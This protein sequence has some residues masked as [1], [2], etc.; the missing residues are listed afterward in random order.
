MQK[1]RFDGEWEILK[2]YKTLD[3]IAESLYIDGELNQKVAT[4][5]HEEVLEANQFGM[6]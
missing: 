6:V 5:S 4:F 3:A 2:K 1:N